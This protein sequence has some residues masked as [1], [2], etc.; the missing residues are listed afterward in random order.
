M[1]H[2]EN[3]LSRFATLPQSSFPCLGELGD[4]GPGKAEAWRLWLNDVYSDYTQGEIAG[5]VA[6]APVVAWLESLALSMGALSD[7]GAEALLSGRSLTH[8]HKLDL[9]HHFLSRDMAKRLAVALPDVRLVIGP[10]ME[11]YEWNP[12]E[13]YVAVSE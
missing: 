6:R 3:G 1:S 10:S 9:H 12:D 8:L 13:R 7:E 5:A 2:H 4:D 11:P